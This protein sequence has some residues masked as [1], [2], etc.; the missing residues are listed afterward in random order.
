MFISRALES[1]FSRR[2]AESPPEG[3]GPQPS[4]S[5]WSRRACL[6]CSFFSPSDAAASK[7]H[8][9]CLLSL[10]VTFSV[11]CIGTFEA[12]RLST[13]I[14]RSPCTVVEREIMDVGTCTMCNIED[15]SHCEV[16]PVATAR[17]RVTFVPQHSH[18]NVTGYVWYCKGRAAADPCDRE[19]RFLDQFALDY[20]T[21]TASIPYSPIP[22][23]T[24]E[25]YAYLGLHRVEQQEQTCYYSSRDPAGEDVW[26]TMPSPVLVDHAWFQKHLEYPVLLAVGGL[27]LLSVL[28]GCLALEG[29][30]LWSS[31]LM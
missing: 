31:G 14:L 3:T 7:L 19:L 21:S 18:T 4:V 5:S 29:T 6:P 8:L 23:T 25:V 2:D 26:L 13:Y 20:R 16:Y 12:T 17:L 24:G 9:W 30:E 11:V 10:L 28:L 15:T 27:V 22:C 1:H